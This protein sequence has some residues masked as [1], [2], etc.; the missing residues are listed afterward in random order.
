MFHFEAFEERPEIAD[1]DYETDGADDEDASSEAAYDEIGG[2]VM[3]FY[4]ELE[5][6]EA[7]MWALHYATWHVPLAEFDCAKHTCIHDPARD[8]SVACVCKVG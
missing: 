5:S 8:V 7:M 1:Y 4:A 6:R 2:S 3:P